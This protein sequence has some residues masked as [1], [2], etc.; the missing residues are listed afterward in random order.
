MTDDRKIL[1]DDLSGLLRVAIYDARDLNPAVYTP[2]CSTYFDKDYSSPSGECS[3]CFAGAVMV[4]SLGLPEFECDTVF[5]EH[6][7]DE[8]SYPIDTADKLRALEAFRDRD[9]DGA[10]ELL[11]L[12]ISEAD[13]AIEEIA[14][15]RYKRVE[16]RHGLDAASFYT[17]EEFDLFLA[18]M[19]KAA[20]ILEAHGF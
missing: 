19:D 13:G 9:Y 20:D 7:E 10:F 17:W 14:A 3:L 18:D 11:D 12:D 2:R 1:P 6:Y 15:M 8:D 5:P 16:E 4:G